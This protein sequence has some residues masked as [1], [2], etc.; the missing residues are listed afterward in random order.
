[1]RIKHYFMDIKEIEQVVD[2][3]DKYAEKYL[4]EP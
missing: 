2:I 3:Y 1:M 4:I